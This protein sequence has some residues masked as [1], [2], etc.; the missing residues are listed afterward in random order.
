MITDKN[1][2][3]TFYIEINAII[4]LCEGFEDYFFK[5]PK[6]HRSFPMCNEIGHY[7]KFRSRKMFIGKKTQNFEELLDI[8][9]IRVDSKFLEEEYYFTALGKRKIFQYESG[10]GAIFFDFNIDPTAQ[11]EVCGLA[12]CY[13]KESEQAVLRIIDAMQ[14]PPMAKSIKSDN[15]YDYIQRNKKWIKKCRN[16]K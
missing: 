4:E 15:I 3:I 16:K 8:L 5:I 1:S 13:P 9:C 10:K 6:K 12:V 7:P 14:Q 11:I 2:F